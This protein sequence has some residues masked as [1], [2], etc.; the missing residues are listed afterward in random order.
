MTPETLA[1]LI[2]LRDAKTPVVLATAL[3]GG[4]Q[5]L[6]PDP[7]AP[8]ARYLSGR[9][10]RHIFTRKAHILCPSILFRKQCLVLAGGSDENLTVNADRDICFRIALHY[11]VVYIDEVLAHYRIL[12]TAMSQNLDRMM[13]GAFQF[14]DKHRKSGVCGFLWVNEALGNVYREWGD[15]YFK[16]GKM[17]TALAWYIKSILKYPFSLRNFYML[18][19][20]LGEPIL[21]MLRPMPAVNSND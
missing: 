8:D 20:A 17:K 9:I 3:P 10:A 5:R 4:A 18:F 2:A 16:V 14:V 19:R 21:E 12:P 13:V 15:E 11:P 7:A 6:L 1:A